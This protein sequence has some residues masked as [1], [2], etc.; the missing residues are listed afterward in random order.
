MERLFE[1]SQDDILLEAFEFEAEKIQ[2]RI[3]LIDV[4]IIAPN[5]CLDF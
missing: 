2:D 1:N 4:E 3:A 5:D